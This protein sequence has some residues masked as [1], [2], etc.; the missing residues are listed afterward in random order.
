MFPPN[1]G[2]QQKKLEVVK[3]VGEDGPDGEYF[4]H[5][6]DV[7]LLFWKGIYEDNIKGSYE[8]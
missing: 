3:M 1:R 8:S 7:L 5:M 2:S 6:N 4:S